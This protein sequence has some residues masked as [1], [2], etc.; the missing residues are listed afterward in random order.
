MGVKADSLLL[1][2][3]VCSTFRLCGRA[4]TWILWVS[5]ERGVLAADV[6]RWPLM[7]VRRSGGA[8][9]EGVNDHELGA[10]FGKRGAG[11]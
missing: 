8:V 3:F 5:S 9:L 1:R 6:A 10:C 4:S 7:T 2:S 11:N